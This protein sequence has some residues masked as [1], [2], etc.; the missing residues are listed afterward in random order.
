VTR[1]VRGPG[2]EQ[3]GALASRGILVLLA[4]LG[5]PT[6]A[7]AQERPIR[8][9]LAAIE[10]PPLEFEQPQIEHHEVEGVPV[11]L[12]ASRELPL[13]T[14]HAYFEGGYG[15]FGRDAYAS[16]MGL[17]ALLRYGGTTDLAPDSVD[18]ILDF[19]AVQTQFG[20]AGGA[21]TS[22]V[23]TLT[24]HLETALD[25]WGE[26]L[27]EPRFDGAEIEVWRGRQLESALR[28]RDDP[29]RLAFSEFNRLLFGDHPIGW[30]MEPD[31]LDPAKVT[32]E[33]FAD[34]H[35]RVVCRENLILGVTG[36]G[37]WS[38]VEDVIERLVRRIAPCP[39]ELPEPPEP[40]IRRGGGVHVIDRDL[41]Q[42]VIV[43]AHPTS[44]RLGDTD[45][46]FSAMIGNSILG[47]G[48]FSS[49]I[50][51]RVR[52]EEGYAY[53]A[54]SLWTTPREHDGILGA[55]TRTRPEN[56]VPAIEV[57]LG[58]MGELRTDPP[59]EGEVGTAVDQVVNGFVFNFETASQIVVRTMLFQAQ[60]LPE[61]WLERYSRGVQAVSPESIREV[62]AAQLRPEEMT[63]LIVGDP[64]RIGRE[65]LEGL[66]PVTLL[67]RR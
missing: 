11:L 64:D 46:Y 43:M 62:F 6:I 34:V 32:T 55:V 67:E 21:V 4:A 19:Y 20:S 52:T 10:Y 17:P 56:A 23:N 38:E 50:L 57:I 36:D 3:R 14:V 1:A 8:E 7:A 45:E 59:T 51:G 48:G 29:G 2:E 44:V 47:G 54:S 53:S 40:D 16:A 26:M 42:A 27:A 33:R 9:T 28:L 12:L 66:G 63:I 30:Q 37:E 49:R 60:E 25:I 39:A 61:D 5:A 31:D 65:A 18:R 35:G 24:E 22:T 13:V 15:L 58:A 41:E